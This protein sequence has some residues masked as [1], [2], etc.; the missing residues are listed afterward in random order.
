[1]PG[2][3]TITAAV[4][5]LA[6][7]NYQFTFV[8]GNLTITKAT[9]TVTADNKTRSQGT[10]NPLLTWSYSGFKNSENLTTSGV[11]GSPVCTTTATQFS[12]VGPYPI[13]CTIGTLAANNY[14]FS[15]VAGTLQVTN[16]APTVTAPP[17]QS[18]NEGESHLFNLGS[19][20]DPGATTDMPWNVDVDWGDN[21]AHTIF[22]M[23]TTGTITPTPHTYADNGLYTVTVKVTDNGGLSDSKTFKVTVNNV[24]PT[25]GPITVTAG[26]P[27]V[28]L[29]GPVPV[30]TKISI[31]ASFTDPGIKD[32]H[33]ALIYWDYDTFN[34]STQNGVTSTGTVTE[35]GGSGTVS[36]SYTF[37][38]AGVYVLE[39]RMTDKDGGIGW[40]PIY[41]YVV[42]YDP[43]GGFVTGGGWINSPL[44]ACNT[45]ALPG[46]CSSDVTGK[47]NF[48]FVSKYQKGANVPTGETQFQFQAGNLNFHSTS[49]QWLVIAGAKAQYKGWGTINGSGNYGFMLTAIDGSVS[50]GGGIDTF[51]IKI[52]VI[53]NGTDGAV[54]YDNMLGASDSAD[55]TTYLGGGSITIH[56][57]K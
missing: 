18:S 45:T 6:A 34:P 53:T 16:V 23:N 40:S 15:F 11:T 22:T 46:V 57:S 25:V 30:N 52:W 42:V 10:A 17:D 8:D 32:T 51:R 47:A 50:G 3:Y 49:Y 29:N 27:P 48:G 7:G 21:S 4:G 28:A 33:T 31:T 36:D 20:T 41:Q 44:G 43:N 19:F 1:V 35:S 26:N 54:V 5:T 13:T 14:D 38:A 55:P 37:T 24:A 2:P 39:V 9:L 12:P 56:G